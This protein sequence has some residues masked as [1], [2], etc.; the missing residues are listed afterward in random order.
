MAAARTPIRRKRPVAQRSRTGLRFNHAMIYTRSL[1]RALAFYGDLLGFEAIDEHPGVYARLASPSGDTT[2]ALHALEP[3]R[4]LAPRTGGLRL[5]FE[6]EAL[7]AFCR[8][9]VRKGV[10]FAQ[11]PQR[12]PWGW[13]HAYLRDP[14]GHE[15][16]LYWAGRARLQ[17]TTVR[18]A[19]G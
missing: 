3:G 17:R 14:D 13:K 10:K 6:V 9:L 8:K 7:D 19:R 4:S 18:H 1:P 11:L 16:S 12:M 2:I 5:Y 15:I